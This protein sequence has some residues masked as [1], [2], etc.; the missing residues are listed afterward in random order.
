M[1]D[2][3][4]YNTF[5]AISEDC[6][7]DRAEVPPVRGGD[8]TVAS[9]QFD[10][11]IDHPYTYTQED[12]LFEVFAERNGISEARKPEMREAFFSKGQACLRTS[13]LAKRYGWGIHHNAEG[14]IA[15]YAVES[16]EYD[17]WLN[18]STMKQ[19]RAM[20]TKKKG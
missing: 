11:L 14:K 5:I 9:Y 1:K 8:K 7:V 10:M 4:Y 13:P 16:G 17:N 12:V 6:P 19:V 20:R 15:I 2:H 18:D 3:N